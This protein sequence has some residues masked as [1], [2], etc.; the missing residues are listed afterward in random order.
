MNTIYIPLLCTQAGNLSRLKALT[1]RCCSHFRLCEFDLLYFTV[2]LAL[3]QS[4]ALNLPSRR[5]TPTVDMRPFILLPTLAC[6]ILIVAHRARGFSSGA[7]EDSRD[8][9]TV[10]HTHVGNPAPGVGCDATCRQ[11]RQLRLIGSSADNFTY[12]CSETYRCE[13]AYIRVR[14]QLW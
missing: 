12:N 3:A 14:L 8:S 5:R 10:N 2:F 4:F 1:P 11:T 9:L 6:L 7:P 13:L